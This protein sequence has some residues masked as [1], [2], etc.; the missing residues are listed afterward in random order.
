MVNLGG[1]TNKMNF[2]KIIL[3]TLDTYFCK[4]SN[5]GPANGELITLYIGYI[6]NF[7]S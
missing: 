1:Y 3:K 6:L 5:F 2:R 7:D 4:G